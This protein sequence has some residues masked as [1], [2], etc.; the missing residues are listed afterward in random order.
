MENIIKKRTLKSLGISQ[1]GVYRGKLHD[2]FVGDITD[3]INEQKMI[4]LI[5]AFGSGKSTVFDFAEQ[6]LSYSEQHRFVHV[7]NVN[8]EKMTINNITDAIIYD[9]SKESPAKSMEARTRQVTRLMGELFVNKGKKLCVVIENAHRLHANTLMA[10]KD[11]REAKYLGRHPLFAVAMIGQ[12]AL[13]NKLEKWE[14]VQWRTL[15]LDLE[16]SA[17]MSYSERVSYLEAVYGQAID[18][19]ARERIALQT[20]T[21]LQIEHFLSEKMDEAVRAGKTQ[22]DGEVVPAGLKERY[23]ALKNHGVSLA[24]IGEAANV[25]K[26][27]ASDTINGTSQS[28]IHLPAITRAIEQFEQ[29]IKSQDTATKTGRAAS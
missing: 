5:G 4:A 21:P 14:E 24:M 15:I 20:R 16:R 27:S 8:K 11:L 6:D 22:I 18:T 17:W 13:R 1:K 12:G 26:S 3:A 7:A 29:K 25:P 19:Q 10:I 9:L 28:G 23:M 2:L